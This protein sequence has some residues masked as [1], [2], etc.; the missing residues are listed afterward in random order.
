MAESQII[1]PE[2]DDEL[3][4]VDEVLERY[5]SVDPEG[6]ELVKLRYFVG[7]TLQEVSDLRGSSLRTV[8]RQWAFARA[9]LQAE[10]E[11]GVKE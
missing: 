1:T 7:F 8:T 10:L 6:A 5:E 2:R 11:I 9:W 3:A 4:A